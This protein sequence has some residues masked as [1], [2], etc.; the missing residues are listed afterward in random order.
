MQTTELRFTPAGGRP[1]LV[2]EDAVIFA[3]AV[4]TLTKESLRRFDERAVMQPRDGFV[5][6][7]IDAMNSVMSTRTSAEALLNRAERSTERL[8]L[9]DE[10][11]SM[12]AMSPADWNQQRVTVKI[13]AAVRAFG[14]SWPNVAVVSKLLYLKRPDLVPIID[15]YVVDHLGPVDGLRGAI[16]L[17]R[18]NCVA[19]QEGLLEI[20]HHLTAEG[21][22]RTPVRILETC[23]WAAH[24]RSPV[25]LEAGSWERV[26][27]R[28]A[29][30]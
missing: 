19:N 22:D 27:R 16:R 1:V 2:I 20:Q 7:D 11:W 15:S 10:S 24:P 12:T 13:A 6:E 23:L 17:F 9:L 26:V 21:I 28:V 30:S 25:R 3:L 29:R 14:A 8:R 5:R 4:F 18:E